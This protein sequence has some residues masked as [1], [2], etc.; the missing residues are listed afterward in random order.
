MK[1]ILL[2]AFAVGCGGSVSSGGDVFAAAEVDCNGVG[3]YIPSDEG[4]HA[5]GVLG[6]AD[7]VVSIA[8]DE[9][10]PP[11]ATL[12]VSPTSALRGE[13]QLTQSVVQVEFWPLDAAEGVPPIAPV[14]LSFEFQVLT[15]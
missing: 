3:C 7:N 2:L 15:H 1:W 12:I 4:F 9:S 8:L 6:I 14:N 13:G 10:V 11:G 5:T